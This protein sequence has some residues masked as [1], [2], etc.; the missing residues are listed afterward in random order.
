MDKFRVRT[1]NKIAA[2]GLKL[3]GE[4]FRVIGFDPLPA[5]DNIHEFPAVG[6]KMSRQPSMKDRASANVRA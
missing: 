4:R 1:M 6:R 5:L 3:F 2:D